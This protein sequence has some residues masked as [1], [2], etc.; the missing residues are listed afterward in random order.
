[1]KTIIVLFG[2]TGDLSRRKLLPALEEIHGELPNEFELVGV[3]RQNV[4]A[5]DI[6]ATD[7]VLL[8]QTTIVTVDL[9]KPEDYQRLWND[10]LEATDVQ[11][12]VYLAVPPL[13]I[14]MIIEHLGSAGFRRPNV[15]LLLEK[16]FGVNEATA[17]QL[18][19]EVCDAFD[20]TQLYFVD[21][22]L[23]KRIARDIVRFR[24]QAATL[25]SVWNHENID[26]IEVIASETLDVEGRAAFYE[27]TGALRDVLQGH[28]LQ[29]L[30]LTVLSL[31][32]F[33]GALPVQRA[34]ALL[35]LKSA[36]PTYAVRGQY[37][38]YREEVGSPNSRVETY[39]ELTFYSDDQRWNGVPMML[40]TGKALDRKETIVRV[41]F[42]AT[43][44]LAGGTLT[45]H[46]QPDSGI[47]TEFVGQG[48]IEQSI[49]QEVAQFQSDGSN[50][51]YESIFLD[52]LQG[53]RTFFVSR[54]EV[55]AS[56]RAVGHVL[57]AW[58]LSSM[59]LVTYAKGTSIED[60]RCQYREC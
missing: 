4:E 27:Q 22:Y 26:R 10:H 2:I 54:H 33:Q 48:H 13:S 12:L 3:T 37:S 30:A 1:M 41:H 57:D 14:P 25:K 21:H 15:K 39:A 38:G 56:W 51:G 35:D 28:L 11:V 5:S 52:S 55:L 58:L 29:L 19:H 31:D 49:Q 42:R 34:Q 24:E 45:F 9:N 46:I 16:P 17:E 50:D 59:P 18:F 7:S 60:I 47:V 36:D 43:N 40:A 53:D 44:H 23:G 8:A 20:E 32:D 6:L